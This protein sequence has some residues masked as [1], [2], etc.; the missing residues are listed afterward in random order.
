[1]TRRD[2][3]KD[4]ILLLARSH[5]HLAAWRKHTSRLM[6]PKRR[7]GA[8]NGGQQ[9]RLKQVWYR[10][11]EPRRIRVGWPLEDLSGGGQFCHPSGVEHQDPLRKLGYYC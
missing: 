3:L 5:P 4:R 9:P 2:G 7:W 11:G 10:S 6:M 8:G 1:M